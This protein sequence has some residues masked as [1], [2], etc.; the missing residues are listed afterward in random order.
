M[1]PHQLWLCEHCA[2]G[3]VS[4]GDIPKAVG[5]KKRVW[6]KYLRDNP[7]EKERLLTLKDTVDFEVED[8][9]LRRALGYT[10]EEIRTAE[11]PGGTETVT[12]QKDVPPDVRAAVEWL[13]I[14]RGGWDEKKNDGMKNALSILRTLDEEAFSD[15]DEC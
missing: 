8:A 7:D 10:A 14:R 9:L 11:K 3:G 2:R 1:T 13:K 5:I 4:L 6:R 15:E 12:T